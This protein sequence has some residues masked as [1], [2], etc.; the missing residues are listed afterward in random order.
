MKSP[1]VKYLETHLKS[2][3]RFEGLLFTRKL[4]GIF[5]FKKK[6]IDLGLFSR[7]Q[8]H[9]FG[10][11]FFAQKINFIPFFQVWLFNSNALLKK[12]FANLFK[13]INQKWWFYSLK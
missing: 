5:F 1:K 4:K 9:S 7:L 6:F 10:R 11:H 2:A 8:N 12:C 13:K 3:L